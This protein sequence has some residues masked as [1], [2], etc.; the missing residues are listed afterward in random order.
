[1][2]ILYSFS[3]GIILNKV[4]ILFIFVLFKAI[5]FANIKPININFENLE[6]S[7]LIKITS[8]IINRNI[9]ITKKIEGKVDFI[10]HNPLSKEELLALLIQVLNSKNY[11]LIENNNI[12]EIVEL[13]KKADR[14][15]QKITKV[16]HL[17]NIESKQIKSLLE[18]L[19]IEFKSKPFVAFEEDFNSVI[20]M[21]IKEDIDEIS[22]LINKIDKR[23]IQIYVEAKI[24]EIS[25][26]KTRNVGVKYGL[27]AGKL[28][29]SSLFTL[30]SSLNGGNALAM[31]S[32]IA[33]FSTLGMSKIFA[34]GATINLLKEN[35]ALEIISEPSILCLD[36]KVSSI[37]VGETRSIKT[38][39]TI[40][41][42]GNT[43]DTYTREDIGLKLSVKPRVVNNEIILDIKTVLEDIK[44]AKTLSGNP[45]TLKKEINTTAIVKDGESVV[46]GGLIKNK[47]DTINESVP[48]FSE[49]PLIGTLFEN[50]RNIK[51]KINLVLIITPHIIHDNEDLTFIRNKLAKF[52]ILENQYTQILKEKLEKQKK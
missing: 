21:G 51:D 28:N 31:G 13:V 16:I 35:E 10:S 46:L 33:D 43:S 30:S 37:Y 41:S 22:D 7:Q 26:I 29:N 8:K 32:A 2:A 3:K 50:K 1:M 5:L 4:I 24:I 45:N 23:R 25:E 15:Y 52:K 20:L 36:N 11:T 38:G 42:G 9:L 19:V 48:F 12:L 39:S 27:K 49:I 18:K 40:T 17:K 47:L 44:Q 6:I 14:K 34:L